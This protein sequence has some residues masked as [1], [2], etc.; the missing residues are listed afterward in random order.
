[1]I[2]K[3][4]LVEVLSKLEVGLSKQ[5]NQTSYFIF[6]KGEILVCS[7]NIFISHP[8]DTGLD[9]NAIAG[10]PMEILKLLKEIKDDEIH[11]KFIKDKVKIKA[12]N[13]KSEMAL[14]QE[15]NLEMIP[16]TPNEDDWEELPANFSEGMN[17][18]KFT[19]GSDSGSANLYRCVTVNNDTIITSDEGRISKFELNGKMDTFSFIGKEINK[20]LKFDVNSYFVDEAWIYFSNEDDVVFSV[21]RAATDYDLETIDTKFDFEG[22][23]ITLP[24]GLPEAIKIIIVALE[25][26]IDTERKTSI[27]INGKKLI[28]RAEKKG[29]GWAEMKINSGQDKD[30]DLEFM[31]HPEF[32]LKILNYTSVMEVGEGRAL[33]VAGNLSHLQALPD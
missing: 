4:E 26:E 27:K 17:L 1:M 18:C 3:T 24:D 32:L 14:L 16:E 28:C 8:F 15:I 9:E 31:I 33:F 7:E 25:R 5:D 12:G 2:D 20:L 29:I 21:R 13:I 22:V 11:F 10:I 19:V 23:K 30:M 6:R